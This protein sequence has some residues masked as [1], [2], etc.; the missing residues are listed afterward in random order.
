MSFFLTNIMKTTINRLLSFLVIT[1]FLMACD[2]PECKNTN[3]MFDN[4]A[5]D[6]R[7][8]KAE[9]VK[10]LELVDHSKLTYWFNKYQESN[11]Q[12]QLLFNV[13]GKGLC[14]VIVLNAEEGDKLEPLRKTKGLGYRGAQFTHL[15]YDIRQDSVKTAFIFRDFEHLID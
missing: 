13:Q 3:P 9:L 4:H 10:Q 12:Q 2:R 5:P 7:E 11:G 1:T 14:A 8:Y 15:T 6:S